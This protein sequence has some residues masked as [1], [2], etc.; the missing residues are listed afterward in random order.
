MH[1]KYDKTT[2]T[3]RNSSISFQTL[4]ENAH[5][6]NSLINLKTFKINYLLYSIKS[7]NVLNSIN[8]QKIIIIKKPE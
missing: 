5:L 3:E 7:I 6:W 8:R 1:C 2:E 4:K